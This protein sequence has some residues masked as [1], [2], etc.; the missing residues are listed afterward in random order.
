VVHRRFECQ[1]TGLQQ[2]VHRRQEPEPMQELD[3]GECLSIVKGRGIGV[4]EAVT[5]NSFEKRVLM[6]YTLNLVVPM[7]NPI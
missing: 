4:L 1:E 2:I 5:R 6:E 3:N 7:D